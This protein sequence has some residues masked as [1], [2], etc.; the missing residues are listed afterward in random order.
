MRRIDVHGLMHRPGASRRV[1]M[2]EQL[3][4]LSTEMVSVTEPIRI[5]G[6]LEGVEEGILVSGTVAGRMSCSCARC[7]KD[8]TQ[9]IDME[10]RE[11]FSHGSSGEEDGY[12]IE[13]GEIDLEPCIRDAVMLSIPFAPLCKEECLGL[14]PRC[15][16][17]RNL[18]E[19]SCGPEIDERWAVLSS[20]KLED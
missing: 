13:E 6:L 4:G 2:S 12:R 3:E 7:L 10:V 11:L 14:C 17:D 8:F 19:C 5:K 15:G 16:G 1:G 18:A 20:L 9:D